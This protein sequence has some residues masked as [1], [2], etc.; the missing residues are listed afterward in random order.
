MAFEIPSA[1]I[2][3]IQAGLRREAGVPFYDPDDPSLPSL[4]SVEDA[5]AAL[6]PDLPPSLRCD[7]CR[8]GLL[9]GLR[10]TIC[11]Y[12]GADRGK[13]GNS[14]SIS[15][16]STVA[17]R[18]L[19]D[20]LGLDGSEAVLL[21][22]EPSGS[23]SNKGQATPKGELVLSDL[24]DLVLRWPSDKEDVEHNSTVTMPSPDTYAL[25]LT[26]IDLDNFFSEKRRETTSFVAPQSD[27]KKMLRENTD[28][29]SHAFS[30]S[31]I[32]AAFE[33]LQ[34]TDNKTNSL[35]NDFGDSFAVWDADFQSAGTKSKEVSPK[36][37]DHFQDS[38][39]HDLARASKTGA[40][41]DQLESIE[42]FD[43]SDPPSVNEQFQDDL[44]PIEN[45]NMYA[46]D[47]LKHEIHNVTENSVS[48][49]VS[50]IG[51]DDFSVQENLWPTS[52]TKESETSIPTNSNEDSFDAWQGFTNSIEA[53]GSSSS[54][55]TAAG[56]G[57]TWPSHS[58]ETKAANIFPAS[59]E[60]ELYNN[61]SIDSNDNCNDD[62]QD[63]AGFEGKGSSTSLGTQSGKAIFEHPEEVKSVDPLDT[64][65]KMESD[66]FTTMNIIHD[67]SDAWPDFTG[68]S[69]ALGNSFNQ[70]SQNGVNS[71]NNSSETIAVDPWS[72]GNSKDLDKNMPLN[73]YDD[74]FNDWQDF[75][76]F[77]EAPKR[78][79]NLGAPSGPTLLEQ[80]SET[81]SVDLLSTKG[82]TEST[83]EHDDSFDDWKDFSSS[84]E[85][86][87]SSSSSG[88]QYKA[89]LFG[90]SSTTDSTQQQ[91][92]K[93]GSDLHTDIFLNQLEGQKSY[94]DGEDI[95]LDVLTSD[96]RVN[97]MDQKTAADPHSMMWE[98]KGTIESSNANS[99]LEPAKSDVEKSSSHIPDLSFMLVDEL[100]I[101]DKS[102]TTEPRL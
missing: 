74:S 6:D 29:K 97:G 86:K 26:G 56:T 98:T 5:V 8:G 61:K 21:D 34:T 24:L 50:S 73:N 78:S 68:S 35:G 28:T 11:I 39:G 83:N 43:K 87:G 88:E 51:I 37:F 79:P 9:R 69:E 95:Q 45:V 27:G 20:Y 52:S 10:S 18:K 82:K 93:F 91:N 89:S 40:T 15:F 60:K 12:C 96:S 16:N 17:C 46:S 49:N 48:N 19:L 101:P 1:L 84:I 67:S 30:G 94:P 85:M 41:I 80:P 23:T 13:E 64:S 99:I 81:K 75:T 44:W 2:R 55:A 59:S 62:W 76:G 58:S 71:H 47:P 92:M 36:S 22:I 54:P 66:S 7:R 70:S 38:S 4:P 90:Y 25:S 65:S 32:F 3:E 42:M 14:H 31:E 33:N 57:L 102:V 100:S 77:A 63:F 72:T 53:R